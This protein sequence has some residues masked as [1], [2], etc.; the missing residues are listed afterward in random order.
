MRD[1]DLVVRA[2][3][4]ASALEGAWHRWR[5][6]YGRVTDPMPAVSS[7]VGYSLEDPWGQPRVVFGLAAEDAEQLAAL[8][9]RHDR[10]EPA[11]AAVTT[12]PIVTDLSA[13]AP[14][15]PAPLPVPRQA[16]SAV[17]NRK[18]DQLLSGQPL[19]D[20]VFSGDSSGYDEPVY[21]QAAAA[22]K[23]AAAA[24][25]LAR[26]A[27]IGAG[28]AP[29]PVSPADSD[30]A[31][32][33]RAGS[34]GTTDPSDAV[35]LVSPA[36]MGSLAMAAVTAKAEA[37]ARIRAVL[38]KPG[39]KS[40]EPSKFDDDAGEGVVVADDGRVGDSHDTAGDS[41]TGLG[42]VTDVDA[43][44][45]RIV[46]GDEGRTE[47]PEIYATDVLEPL[48][49]AEEAGARAPGLEEPTGALSPDDQDQDAP[50]RD[51]VDRVG[52][53]RDADDADTADQDA[54]DQD[55]V[56]QDAVDQ[57]AVDQAAV[58]QAA[59]DGDASDGD[60]HDKD[61][62]DP[63][64]GDGSRETDDHDV[65]ARDQSGGP[66]SGVAKRGR[67]TRSYPIARLSKTKRSG[68][69]NQPAGS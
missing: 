12:Q 51:A 27:K 9:E 13:R 30:S 63:D 44:D 56:D 35:N 23:E 54:V 22:M 49:T 57:D 59:S 19:A 26:R 18:A 62:D 67:V 31:S 2:Q 41:A 69:S 17:A 38:T 16:P 45:G 42:D 47:L 58:G 66:E 1:P 25:D 28:F 60:A 10:A 61:A 48:P 55:A 33:H 21:R 52:S 68:A 53:D 39:R 8:L 20:L 46:D 3:M 43:A 65:A 50:D 29:A 64:L 36:W 4:A 5:V 14:A 32:E 15:R 6:G 40:A 7:Y 11:Y 34:V 37:E 24:R